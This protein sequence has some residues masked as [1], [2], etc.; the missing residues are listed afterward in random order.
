MI[1]SIVECLFAFILPWF[2]GPSYE[3]RPLHCGFTA[4]LFLLYPVVGFILAGLIEIILYAVAG[5]TQF[6]KNI[7]SNILSSSIATFTIVLAF[8]INLFI[9]ISHSG[10]ISKFLVPLF[11][12]M[13]LIVALFLST[14]SNLWFKRLRFFTNPLTACLFL[15]GTSWLI[16]DLL[17]Y[18][19]RLYK[20][21]EILIF[22]VVISFISFLVVKIIESFRTRRS[23]VTGTVSQTWPFMFLVPALLIVFGANFFLEQKPIQVAY[24]VKIFTC[25]SQQP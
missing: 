13:I 6:I 22:A 23:S 16:F 14:I 19:A 24:K 15:V 8:T 25:K 4:V 2:T 5:K 10:T 1:Y 17:K 18:H 9:S 7:E 12:S 21:L 11:V 20:V 3:Y